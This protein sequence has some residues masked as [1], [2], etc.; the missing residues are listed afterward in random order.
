MGELDEQTSKEVLNSGI[1]VYSL[2]DVTKP[3]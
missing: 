2:K 1:E 3:I